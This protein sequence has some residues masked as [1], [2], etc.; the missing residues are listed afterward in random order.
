[1]GEDQPEPSGSQ[2]EEGKMDGGGSGWDGVRGLTQSLQHP[3]VLG[4]IE[5]IRI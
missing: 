4:G 2:G 5:R 3:E 1:M